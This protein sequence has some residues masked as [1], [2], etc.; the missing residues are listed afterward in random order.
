M[1][2]PSTKRQRQDDTT[3]SLTLDQCKVLQESVKSI[4]DLMGAISKKS[5]LLEAADEVSDAVPPDESDWDSD[6]SSD[7]ESEVE[8]AEE[9]KPPSCLSDKGILNSAKNKDG[10]VATISDKGFFQIWLGGTCVS[11][12]NFEDGK[13]PWDHANMYWEGDHIVFSV[14]CFVFI[15]IFKERTATLWRRPLIS[16]LQFSLLGLSP[17]GEH[18]VTRH[19]EDRTYRIWDSKTLKYSTVDYLTDN[20]EFSKDGS[21]MYCWDPAH[22]KSDSSNLRVWNVKDGS[23]Q[24]SKE[25]CFV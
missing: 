3:V 19:L 17:S 25:L 15:I 11:T 2:E 10:Y 24:I 13:K 12:E 22:D 14:A 1:T 20:V 8:E 7:E 4:A 18:F 16:D 21:L 23:T 6:D 9:D 5:Q